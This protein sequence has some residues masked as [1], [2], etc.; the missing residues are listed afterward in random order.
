[1]DERTIKGTSVSLIKNLLLVINN[2]IEAG[3]LF[4]PK[5][6]VGKIM[7]NYNYHNCIFVSDLEDFYMHQEVIIRLLLLEEIFPDLFYGLRLKSE[8]RGGDTVV[9]NDRVDLVKNKV[10]LRLDLVNNIISK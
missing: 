1:M 6:D 4:V 5:S 8:F 9:E 7:G 10:K 2:H 3:T